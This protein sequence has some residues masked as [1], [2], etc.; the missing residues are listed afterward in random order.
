MHLGAGPLLLS[1][2]ASTA[3]AWLTIFN[4]VMNS[5]S[6]I[7]YFVNEL[8]IQILSTLHPEVLL[9]ERTFDHLQLSAC[10]IVVYDDEFINLSG[11]CLL[12][13]T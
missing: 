3:S 7:F 2:N 5:V 11:F 9:D 10:N 4:C 12:N 8:F 6:D 1:N 13:R